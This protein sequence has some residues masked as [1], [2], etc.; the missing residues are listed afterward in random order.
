LSE[1]SWPWDIGL[2]P[3]FYKHL[4]SPVNEDNLA[5]L[6]PFTLNID[7]NTLT[8]VQLPN[9]NIANNLSRAYMSGSMITGMMDEVGIGKEY[10][11]DF[12]KFIQ[13]S[14]RKSN[15]Q[16]L[17]ILEIGCG[18]GYLLYCLKSLGATVLGV[19]PGLHGQLGREKFDIKV[20]NDFFPSDKVTSKFDVIILYCVLE[21][22]QEPSKFL[23]NL[24]KYLNNGGNILIAVPNCEPYIEAGDVSMLIHEHYNYYT[25][26]S[27]YHTIIKSTNM[28]T[29]IINSGFGGLLYAIV[30]DNQ[31]ESNSI[32]SIYEIDKEI[33]CIEYYQELAQK[34][35]DRIK[36]Y[37]VQANLKKE[38]VGIYVPG[39]IINVLS[40]IREKVDLSRIR[41]F[42]DNEYLH[43]TYYPGINIPIESRQ[44]LIS[45]PTDRLLIMSNSFGN[46]LKS[47]L[48][49]VLP[50]YIEIDNWKDLFQSNI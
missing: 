50:K 44:D 7:K 25:R 1:N 21:H 42:D 39:R 37:F 33:E 40:I 22:I 32:N 24:K 45:N 10:T 15:L 18:N 23:S 19:E 47:E 2:I 14:L 30:K 38:S 17:N 20:I 43:N 16:D 36:N 3:F 5:N 6:L 28:G 34:N 31:E 9:E 46:K 12:L 29:T 49:E 4:Q 35:V 26:V 13:S 48:K 41:F 27:L 11:D 8:L